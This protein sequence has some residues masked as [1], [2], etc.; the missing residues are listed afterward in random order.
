MVVMRN[1]DYGRISRILADSTPVE[2]EFNQQ[3]GLPGIGFA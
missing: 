2:L 1:Q 3:R